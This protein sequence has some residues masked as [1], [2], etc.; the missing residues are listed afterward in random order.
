M[1]VRTGIGDRGP[2]HLAASPGIPVDSVA[3]AGT[4]YVASNND[5][6]IEPGTITE[7][8]NWFKRAKTSAARLL[9]VPLM[10]ALLS[11]AA[12]RAW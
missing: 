4:G 10:F 8:L 5:G 9:A 11:R 7:P 3:A 1:V 2:R 6:R 12:E